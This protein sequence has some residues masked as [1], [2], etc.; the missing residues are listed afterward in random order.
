MIANDP[1]DLQ[2]FVS[3]QE[4]VFDQA[5][6]ELQLGRKS[7]HWMWFIFPQIRGL[8]TSGNAR[9]Y[10][11]SSRE[12]A[13]AYL[14]HPVLGPRLCQCVN[15]M[16]QLQGRTLRQILGTPD[17]LKFRSCMTLFAH[18]TANNLSFLDALAKY[19]GSEFDAATLAQL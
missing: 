10:A 17:D 18:A 15:A 6:G 4:G 13:A 3:A 19:C 12:E 8:G 1:F 5:L 14:L 2:R 16:L 7:S 11:L 9:L